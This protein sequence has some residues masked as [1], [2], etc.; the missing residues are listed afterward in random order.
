M[1]NQIVISSGAKVREL[2]GVLTGTSGIVNAL[3]IN[4]PSGIPQL[5]GSGKIL[6]SQLPNSVMEYKGSW[7]AATN[8]PTLVNGTG[9]A[10]DVYL[11]EVAGT[12]NFGAGPITFAVGDQ[13]IYSGAIWQRASGATGT[14]TSVAVTES[15]DALTITGS[16][17]TTSGTINIGFAGTS[18]QYVNGAGGLT[19]FP[20]LTGFVPYTG[21]TS[22]VDLGTNDLIAGGISSSGIIVANGLLGALGG[23]DFQK[24]NIPSSF[25]LG[26]VIL[27]AEAS[28]NNIVFRDNTSKAKLIFNNSDQTYTFPAIT[29]T[30]ALLEG[31]QTFSGSKIFSNSAKF[32]SLVFV[33]R[34]INISK[35]PSL[36]AYTG[37][38]ITNYG[39]TSG[40]IYADGDTSNLSTLNFN[41]GGNY[42]YTFPAASG[43]IA[44]TS[45]LSSYVPYTG[46][47][48]SVDL[49][50]NSLY[51]NNGQAIFGRNFTGTFAYALI[52]VNPSNKVSIDTSGLGTIFGG[53]IIAPTITATTNTSTYININSTAVSGTNWS[54]NSSND[55]NLYLAV[56][57]GSGYGL[58][59]SNAN[60]VDFGSTIGNGTF[61][62][63]LPSA[64]GTLALTSNLSG[65]VPY[66]GATANVNLGIYGLLAQAI[67]V[68]QTS[69]QGYIHFK[70][71]GSTALSADTSQAPYGTNG[72][73][74]SF[75]QTGGN[76]KQFVIDS[77]LLTNNTIRTYSMPNASGTLA[78]TSD[79]GSYV[80]YTGATANVN[81]GTFDLTA[82]VITGATGSFAS[83]GGS[84]TFAINHSSGSGIALNITKGGNGEGLYINKTSGSGNALTVIGSTSLGALSGTSAT[85]SG[86]VT[87]DDLILTAGTLFGTGNTG[88][89]NRASD[90]TLYLQM[91]ATGFNITDNAL[92]TKFIFSSN[93]TL[94][95]EYLISNGG[96]QI[97]TTTSPLVFF[98]SGG[99]GNAKRFG[100]NMTNLDAFKIYSLNDN[101]TTRKD[102]IIVANID[103]NVGVGTS[104]SEKL[105]ILG[106]N[107]SGAAVKWQNQGGRK[108]GYLYSDSVGVAI[109]DTNLNDAGIYLA[110]NTQIDFRVNGSQRMLITS[111]GQVQI[112]QSADGFTEGLRWINTLGNRW[113]FV[114]GADNNFYIGF[115][116]VGKGV[117]NNSTGIYTPLSDV[118][119]KKD[120]E[121]STIGLN[122]ILGL[123][124]TLY[125]MKTDETKGK[126]EL[127]FIAQEVKEFIPQAYSESI[128]GDD[129]FIGLNYNA[130]VAALVKSVQELKAEIDELKNN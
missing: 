106:P 84:D 21:A 66:T 111:G 13:V 68:G 31:S 27:Y 37:G 43:T 29:G 16:P 82:D 108:A 54:I 28:S 71:G 19:T 42:T 17:I 57:G 101:G 73:I 53:S 5:D 103:G 127:G 33:D 83:S 110:G 1:S 7:N 20:S 69:T 15:G 115:N 124:P 97:N 96:G 12:V 114:N 113:S 76:Y 41:F 8:T 60:K 94:T 2:E 44:L 77:S 55:G 95:A 35:T 74:Y 98:N 104:P 56:N 48:T 93:G 61:T 99:G 120:F 118:N 122:A 64:T 129:T 45:N 85:F 70:T 36:V 116:E 59:I 87:S 26:D 72:M 40:I 121:A 4:V 14:V 75:D 62:Y 10:G 80:P 126:K 128:N 32:T 11:C 105:D 123:K 119:K 92:N 90:T 38:Y 24:G 109:Y 107:G 86:A 46:A 125:R 100:L 3:G 47:T 63:T 25:T 65:Y 39:T 67:V 6:V 30:L 52:G 102:N 117:F 18:G 130:I 88:F 58:R 23:L 91:P 79:L 22:N 81:L 9:N 112:K 50:G 78:L 34:Q 49:G 51:F 89:S